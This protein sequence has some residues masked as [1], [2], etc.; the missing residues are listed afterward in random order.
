MTEQ[1][2]TVAR[3]AETLRALARDARRPLEPEEAPEAILQRLAERL[4]E[5]AARL[6]GTKP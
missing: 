5:E 4:E 2:R 6:E 3:V 1:Q